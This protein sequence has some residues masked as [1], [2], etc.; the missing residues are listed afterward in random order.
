MKR[1]ALA[2]TLILA[3]FLSAVAGAQLSLLP[4]AN[5]VFPPANPV[6]TIESP[7]NSTYKVTTLSLEVTFETYKTGYPGGPEYPTTRQ[8]TYILDGKAPEPINITNFSVA[9]NPGGDVFFEGS[10]LLPELTEGL[11]NLTVCVVFD[12]PS[13]TNAFES[14]HTESKSSVYFRIDT[15]AQ[16]ISIL[17]PENST[18]N[19]TE[20]PL[21]FFI[22][23]PA[24]WTGYSLDGQENVTVTG[25]MTLPELSVG[26]HNLTLYA[27]DEAGNPT[28]SGTVTFDVVESFPTALV[29]A[30]SGVCVAVVGLSL[31]VFFKRKRGK[32]T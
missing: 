17:M 2:L 13:D 21:Q 22:D 18:Y 10:A 11:H 4:K 28:A 23:E 29:V 12:Y 32:L 24:S 14:H 15:V 30:T 1:T 25:N 6:I 5:F 7:T 26:Q 31:L 9:I 16:N 3:L 8:F 19:P 20:V 27:E